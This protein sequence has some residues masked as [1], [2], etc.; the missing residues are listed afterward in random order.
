M[1]LSRPDD[2]AGVLRVA[3]GQARPHNLVSSRRDWAALLTRGVPA[4]SLASRLG[5][6]FSLC[7]HA[8]RLCADMA[9]TAALGRSTPARL[10]AAQDLQLE[11]LREHVRRI[12][13]DWPKQLALGPASEQARQQAHAALQQCPL[14]AAVA[15]TRSGDP[16]NE[17]CPGLQQWLE[18]QL[19]GMPAQV[20]LSQWEQDPAA[21]LRVWT[22]DSPGWLTGLLRQARPLADRATPAAPFLRVH[23]SEAGLRVL[24]DCLVRQPGFTRQPLWR[25]QCAETGPWTRLRQATP[26]VINTPWLRLGARL[27]ELVRLALADEAGR[28]GASWLTMGSMATA[29]REGLAWVEMARGLLVHHVQLDGTGDDAR[30]VSCQVLAPTEWNFHPQGAVA[31]A[32]EQLPTPST[33]GICRE[34]DLLFSAYDPCV[35]HELMINHPEDCHA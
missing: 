13:L 25:G 22:E 1:T 9:V 23:T 5:S 24:A 26:E 34:V 19:L 17:P 30:V 21:W 3:P 18:T 20:W 12:G 29:R 35:K 31:Q 28:S 16:F 11:T 14:F 10:N 8:H 15:S 32:L 2:L 7:G 33:S 4:T 6:L 27:A